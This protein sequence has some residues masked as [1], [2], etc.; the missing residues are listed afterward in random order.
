MISP[1]LLGSGPLRTVIDMLNSAEGRVATSDILD[2]LLE[3]PDE[4]G[5]A[6]AAEFFAAVVATAAAAASG[7]TNGSNNEGT[8][9]RSWV[10]YVCTCCFQSDAYQPDFGRTR[11][12]SMEFALG[13]GSNRESLTRP[14]SKATC[15]MVGW[16]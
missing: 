13:V 15:M 11:R 3:R 2:G 7:E 8:G 1:G 6:L 10:R 5:P 16:V 14:D 4:E 9:S 12:D